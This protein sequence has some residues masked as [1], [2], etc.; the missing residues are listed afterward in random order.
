MIADYVKL[1]NKLYNVRVI[2][3]ERSFKIKQSSN[4]GTAL[5]VGSP[6]ILDPLGTFISYKV[7]FAPIV[8]Y[9][10][11]YDKLWELVIYPYTDGID[12]DIVYNQT[13][14]QF[15]AQI[16]Q[17]GWQQLKKINRDSGKNC[18]GELPLELTPLKAQVL[19]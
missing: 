17:S 14:I 1:G 2:G 16:Q 13:K 3:L 11:D 8:G 19:P 4:S 15:K 10:S 18:W 6:E 5:A 7:T 12:V 9:E